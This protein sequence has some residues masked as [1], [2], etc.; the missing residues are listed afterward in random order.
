[1]YQNGD[2]RDDVRFYYTKK[3]I[4]ILHIHYILFIYIIYILYLNVN[5]IIKYFLKNKG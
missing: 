2:F 1:M 5:L 3:K 4:I